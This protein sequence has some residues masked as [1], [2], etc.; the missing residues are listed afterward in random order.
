VVMAGQH[1]QMTLDVAEGDAVAVLVGEVE[2][3]AGDQLERPRSRARGGLKAPP[4]WSK[5]TFVPSASVKRASRDMGCAGT[6][7][8]HLHPKYPVTQV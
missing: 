2:D 1:G 6:G 8:L 7:D 5:I 3:V 4:R